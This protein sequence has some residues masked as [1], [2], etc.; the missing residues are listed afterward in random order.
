M[1]TFV[2]LIC[3]KHRTTL[4]NKIKKQH[5]EQIF[6]NCTLGSDECNRD[7]GSGTRK[8]SNTG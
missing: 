2:K 4:N 1:L 8:C 5:D 3:R 7:V 6:Q